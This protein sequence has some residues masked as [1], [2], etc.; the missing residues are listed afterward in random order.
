SNDAS[1][2]DLFCYELNVPPAT[3]EQIKQYMKMD[4]KKYFGITVHNEMRKIKCLVL[5]RSQQSNASTNTISD[6]SFDLQKNTLK[7]YIHN[8]SVS[9]ALTLLNLYS[10]IPIIDDSNDKG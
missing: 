7:K 5:Q 2:T 4:L 10:A 1:P 8:R 6:K 9:S 3:E